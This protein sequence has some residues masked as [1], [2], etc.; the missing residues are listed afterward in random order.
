MVP[1]I[2]ENREIYIPQKIVPVRYGMCL[3]MQ[4]HR[5][6]HTRTHTQAHPRTHTHTH[7]H[8]LVTHIR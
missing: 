4:T 3:H 8:T 5:R 7:T 2:R 6:A 1:V